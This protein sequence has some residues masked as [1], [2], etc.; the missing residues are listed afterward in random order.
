MTTPASKSEFEQKLIESFSRAARSY[1]R[2]AQIQ[3]TMAERLAS[4]LPDPLP[5]RILEIGCGTGVFT[6][7]ILARSPR[8]LLLNDLAP[9]MIDHLKGHLELPAR[10]LVL[11]GN[12][13]TLRFPTV[14][15][16]AANAVFQWFLDPAA[17]LKRLSQRLKPPGALVFSTFGSRTLEEF[18][19]LASLKGPT[20]LLSRTQ[21]QQ[22]LREAGFRILQKQTESREVFF[23]NTQELLKNLQ[24]IGAAPARQMKPALLKQ[25]IREYDRRYGTSQGVYTHWEILYFSA[26]LIKK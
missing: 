24:Q 12:A 11:L 17:T 15:L 3:R 8:R 10:T 2:H 4:F 25:L 20:T 21:W 14:D 22:V 1:D 9:A 5:R 26:Q 23:K 18:R 6:R 13:E 7:H 16:I 19:E